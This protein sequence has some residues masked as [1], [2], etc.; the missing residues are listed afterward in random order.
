MS[1]AQKIDAAGCGCGAPDPG[2]GVIDIDTA[3][4][5]IADNVVPVMG[6]ER[7][8]LVLAR[9]RVLA[10]PVRALSDMPRFDHA[11]MDGY[12]LRRADLA[13]QG[14][15][16]LPVT[17]RCAAG[18]APGAPLEPGTAARI[19]T[20]APMPEGADCVVMQEQV[21]RD[22]AG[23]GLGRCPGQHENIRY[24]GEEH[25]AGDE[26][27]TAGTRVTDRVIAAAAASGH[28]GLIVTRRLRVAL[29]VSGTEVTQAGAADLGPAAIWDV[30]TPMLRAAL[31]RPD[32]DLVAVEAVPDSIEASRA[33]LARAAQDADLV[34]TTGGV[35]VGEEDHLREAVRGLGGAL[36]FAGVSMKPGKPVSFGKI[37]AALWLGLPGNPQSAF[38]AWTLF[39]RAILQ[40]LAG[41]AVPDT[42]QGT[43]ALAQPV[44][45]RAG[46]C[47]V[48]AAR[49]VGTDEA[50]RALVACD[51]TIHSG[52]VGAL[53]ASDGLVFLPAETDRL[54]QGALVRFLPFCTMRG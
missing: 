22:A 33:A 42:R 31:M 28:S 50:G 23:I 26:I 14:P 9:G 4:V 15:W 46:R 7:A 44:A 18:E 12:A 25:R 54:P 10:E 53:A 37:G 6:C 13:G 20:G 29:L 49:L 52:Q 16:H 34:I 36:V 41:L 21:A 48:R 24:R 35:S 45:R 17:L 2:M 3:L 32:I 27:V 11:A 47:E 5:R 19:F 43:V 8:D 1:F 51:D 38:V 39:G 40:R 30:N